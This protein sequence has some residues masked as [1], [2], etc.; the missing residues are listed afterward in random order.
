MLVNKEAAF[1]SCLWFILG[2]LLCTCSGALEEAVAAHTHTHTHTHQA[3]RQAVCPT[4]H[5]CFPGCLPTSGRSCIVQAHTA[6]PLLPACR[7]ILPASPPSALSP[8][9]LPLPPPPC[10]A[11]LLLSQPP[12]TPCPQLPMAI[13]GC[14]DSATPAKAWERLASSLPHLQGS[15]PLQTYWVQLAWAAMEGGALQRAMLRHSPGC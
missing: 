4:V 9:S 15:A 10:Y 6:L 12:A 11:P 1:V 8:P 2:R 5:L 14:L 3:G 7:W 13:G